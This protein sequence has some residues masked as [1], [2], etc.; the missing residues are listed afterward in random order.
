MHHTQN[1]RRFLA[2]SV[3][4]F[5][6]THR[7]ATFSSVCRR[8]RGWTAFLL[9]DGHRIFT[10]AEKPWT[11]RDCLSVALVEANVSQNVSDERCF[12]FGWF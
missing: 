5:R 9:C 3:K 12:P 2:V 7:T 11:L 10:G 6:E 4:T 1:W 8:S